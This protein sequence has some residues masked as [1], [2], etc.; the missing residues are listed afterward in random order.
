MS[1]LLRTNLQGKTGSW[2]VCWW[3]TALCHT[4][5]VIKRTP[6]RVKKVIIKAEDHAYVVPASSKAQ[7][8]KRHA[9]RNSKNPGKSILWKVDLERGGLRGV[10]K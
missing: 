9:V 8:N 10:W 7:T 1:T 2:D 4:K 6:E 3:L 5:N